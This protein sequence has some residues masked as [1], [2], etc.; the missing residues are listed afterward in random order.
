M[1]C[2]VTESQEEVLKLIF[3]AVE[4]T[5]NKNVVLSGGYALNCVAN[6]WYL[7]KLTKK[8]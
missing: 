1:A 8:V 4:M 6:Y 5:G 3:K 7:D 2:V